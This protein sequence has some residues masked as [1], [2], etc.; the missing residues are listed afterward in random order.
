[1]AR[2]KKNTFKVEFSVDNLSLKEQQQ[3]FDILMK[4]LDY[5]EKEGLH[6]T[7]TDPLGGKHYVWDDKGEDPEGVKCSRCKMIDC[8]SCVLYERRMELKDGKEN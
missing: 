3:I 7:V 6:I 8:S 5:G 2:R 1:M 4:N